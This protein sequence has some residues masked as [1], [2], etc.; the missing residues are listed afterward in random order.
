MSWLS[1][2]GRQAGS[3]HGL[4]PV[5]CLPWCGWGPVHCP[6]LEGW[7]LWDFSKCFLQ[8]TVFNNHRQTHVPSIYHAPFV[9]PKSFSLQGT[10][11]P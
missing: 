6:A 8:T 4:S 11:Q 10:L 1:G 9:L 7:W 3:S 2:P 5:P